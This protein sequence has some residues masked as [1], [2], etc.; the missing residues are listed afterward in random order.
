M[1]TI[2]LNKTVFERLVGK[3]LP[4]DQL[5][6][7]ISMLGT[8]LEKI[9]GNEIQVEI[10]PNRPDMLSEQGFARAFSS[11]I[12]IK[13]G[14]RKYSTKSSGKKVIIEPSVK[15]IRPFTACAIV[16][17]LQLDEEKIREII[18]IQEKL[19]ITYGRNRKKAAIGVYPMEKITFPVR[20]KASKPENISFQPLGSTKA[21]SALQ[22]LAQHKAGQEFGHLLENLERFPY[23]IDANDEILSMPPIINSHRTGRVTKK[24]N[25]LFIECSGFDF[26]TLSICLNIIVTALADMGGSILTV[27]LQYE[28]KRTTPDLEPKKMKLNLP[29]I[30]NRLGLDLSHSEASK[31]L[32]RMGFGM[33]K[34]TVL[35]P[36]Y[37]ADILHQVDFVEDIAIAYGYENFTEEIPNVATI[38]QEN[39]VEKFQ[40]KLQEIC[41]GFGLL[42]VKNY[43]LL[44]E[45]DLNQ[46]MNLNNKL[47][48]LKNAVGDHNHLR[49]SLLP[50][51]IKTLSEN[52]HHEYP[53]NIFEIGRTFNISKST[54]TGVKESQLLSIALCNEKADFTQVRQL[55]DALLSSLDVKGSVKEST[56]ASFI[57]GRMGTI[58]VNGKSVGIIGEIHPQV[59]TAWNLLMPVVVFELNIEKIM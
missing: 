4:L 14:L 9:E 50:S 54:E 17:G 21:M 57:P 49:N 11:F 5:K 8:D 15:G 58:M 33:E 59:L 24:T 28:K 29:Y 32:G 39:Q 36:S 12:G 40:R 20:Y 18:Q 25:D 47:I 19:H 27:D 35:I 44:M 45:S 10:F 43:H 52:Q 48:P 41:I 1:P 22:I 2:T 53:Q 13:T 6:D 31:L 37:R 46:K 23:F 38:G 3:K 16:K 55:L 30:N 34:N 7:R 42:E 26:K 51:L 56:H